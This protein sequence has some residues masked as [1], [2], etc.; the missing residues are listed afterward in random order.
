MFLL[1]KGRQAQKLPAWDPTC[2]H[3]EM[4]SAYFKICALWMVKISTKQSLPSWLST[5][6]FKCLWLENIRRVLRRLLEGYEWGVNEYLRCKTV[7][8]FSRHLRCNSSWKYYIHIKASPDFQVSEVRKSLKTLY[9]SKI[10]WSYLHLAGKKTACQALYFQTL[11]TPILVQW[12][13][14]LET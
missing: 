3:V 13:P 5:S 6:R 7:M 9:M 8:T 1:C 4:S 12:L 2:T 10:T 11:P 14:V